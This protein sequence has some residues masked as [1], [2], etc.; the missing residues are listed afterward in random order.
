MSDEHGAQV[1]PVM[2]FTSLRGTV[3]SFYKEV[4]GL[5]GDEKGDQIWLDAGNVK[6]VVSQKGDAQTPKEVSGQLGF[7]VW[8]GVA[9]VRGAYEKARKLGAA[10]SD[11]FGDYFFARDPDGRYVGVYALEDHAHGHDHEH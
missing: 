1:G 9:D 4:I 11:F 7:V 3:S 6:V 5:T 2:V 8:F 10:A